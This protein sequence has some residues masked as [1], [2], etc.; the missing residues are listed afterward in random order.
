MNIVR[1]NEGL[2]MMNSAVF[3]TVVNPDGGEN[4]CW[5]R[6]LTLVLLTL[7]Q[8][9]RVLQEEMFW[10]KSFNLFHDL[11]RLDYISSI[12]AVIQRDWCSIIAGALHIVAH[13]LQKLFECPIFLSFLSPPYRFHRWVQTAFPYS[14][15]GRTIVLYRQIYFCGKGQFY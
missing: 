1:V 11:E 5:M 4:C 6:R 10:I 8:W 9:L 12:P 7:R 13:W 2:R 3:L 15:I 14:K